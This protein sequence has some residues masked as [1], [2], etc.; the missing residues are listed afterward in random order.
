MLLCGLG[1]G[2]GLD[3]STYTVGTMASFSGLKLCVSINCM[4]SSSLGSGYSVA[5]SEMENKANDVGY[6]AVSVCFVFVS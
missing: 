3:S 1:V 2:S 4:V 5:N 6:R